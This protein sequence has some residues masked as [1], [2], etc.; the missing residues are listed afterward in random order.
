MSMVDEKSPDLAEPDRVRLAERAVEPAGAAE[1]DDLDR[2][3]EPG[4][5]AGSGAVAR[6]V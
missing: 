3:E 2:A 4:D 1:A 6:G 5:E